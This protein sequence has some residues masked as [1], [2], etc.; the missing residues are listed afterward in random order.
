MEGSAGDRPPAEPADLADAVIGVVR[1]LRPPTDPAFVD[2]TPVELSVMRAIRQRP[3]ASAREVSEATLLPSSNFSRA[4]RALEAKG[5]ISRDVDEQDARVVRLFPT[6]LAQD[7]LAAL[8]RT[9]SE[10]L[11]GLIDDPE[12][13]ARVVETLRG[14]EEELISRRRV[15]GQTGRV[16][17][18][19]L[20]PRDPAD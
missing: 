11:S 15:A 19:A 6:Q 5:L 13:L 1:Q 2:C 4:L 14:V 9:W 3:G 16:Y 20:I 8:R 12:E 7:S 18:V 10:T 17:D